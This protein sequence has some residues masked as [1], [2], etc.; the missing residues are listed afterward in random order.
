M[1]WLSTIV[2]GYSIDIFGDVPFLSF[3]RWQ[4][5]RQPVLSSLRGKLREREKCGNQ[6]VSISIVVFLSTWQ[7]KLKRFFLK[8]EN[9]SAL[10]L[11]LMH[12]KKTFNRLSWLSSSSFL[13][14]FLNWSQLVV[15]FKR[16][17][18]STKL[19]FSGE[20]KREV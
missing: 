19:F 4:I 10:I 16:K 17:K 11:A 1:A 12:M 20:K 2:L 5:V 14:F 15:S 9:N 8:N 3:A 18:I 7:L 13:S 6:I